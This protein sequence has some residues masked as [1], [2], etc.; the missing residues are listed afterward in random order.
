M[1]PARKEAIVKA[2]AQSRNS[3]SAIDSCHKEYAL[4]HNAYNAAVVEMPRKGR[5]SGTDL[6]DLRLH[7]MSAY[8]MLLDVLRIH[9]DN[10]AHLHALKG[11]L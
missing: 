6:E 8:E 5:R 1:S 9:S 7:A 2:M 4:A 11:K 3:K 10:I